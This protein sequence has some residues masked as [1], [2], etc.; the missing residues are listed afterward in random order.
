MLEEKLVLVWPPATPV[1]RCNIAVRKGQGKFCELILL[2][3]MLIADLGS[4]PVIDLQSTN[5]FH[6]NDTY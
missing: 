5:P 6:Y 3:V 1:S 4:M 2:D